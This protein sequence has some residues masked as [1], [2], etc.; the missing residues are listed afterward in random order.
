MQHTTIA[1][2]EDV[3]EALNSKKKVGESF[4]DMLK[5]EMNLEE[6]QA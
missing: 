1:V 6:I 4:N 3:W 2:S 5:R